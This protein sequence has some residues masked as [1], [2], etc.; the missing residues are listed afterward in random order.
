[1]FFVAIDQVVHA[2]DLDRATGGSTDIS[3][4]LSTTLLGEALKTITP[5][6]RGPDGSAAFGEEQSPPEG[7]TAADQLAAFLGRTN[8]TVRDRR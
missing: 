6:M 5:D 1:M 2:W 7:A 3:P 4:E 8:S